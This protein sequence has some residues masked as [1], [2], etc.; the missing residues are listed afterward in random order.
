MKVA[1]ISS[2][3]E[4]TPPKRYGGTERIVATLADGLVSRGHEVTI[5][6]AAGSESRGTVVTFWE[7][8]S[9]PYLPVVHFAH[10]V[11]AVATVASDGFDIVHNH[12]EAGVALGSVCPTP[13]IST[14][15]ESLGSAQDT[16]P[17][18]FFDLFPEA[19]LVAISDHQAGVARLRRMK[20]LG[21]IYNGI[22][23]RGFTFSERPGQYLAFLGLLAPHKGPQHAIAVARET[24]LP[25]KIAGKIP[26]H[27]E[28]RAF[29]ETAVL[30][31]CDGSII[32]FVGEL[33]E[34]EK[35]GFLRNALC[36][37][38]PVE[39]EEPFGLVIAEA[40]AC[41]TPVVGFARGSLPEL[42]GP[43]T[44]AITTCIREMC[45]A[46]DGIGKLDRLAIRTYAEE[47][48]DGDRM[49]SEYEL[50]YYSVLKRQAAIRCN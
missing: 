50:L 49:V 20:V 28:Y 34:T 35:R 21:R 19:S 5:F 43:G 25:L 16:R 42:I 27:P 9:R 6:A 23:V 15:H 31:A 45:R 40:M 30:A 26:T 41:G 11:R 36:L 38:A 10:A 29:F 2:P 1:L 37:L 17:P 46:V 48:F 7:G 14:I 33:T 13:M 8:P 22:D 32:E 18:T 12:I 3:Y 39:W 24:G 44:G 4:S 47:R